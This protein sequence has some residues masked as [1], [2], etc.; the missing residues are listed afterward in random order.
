MKR[1]LKRLLIALG[2]VIAFIAFVGAC[3]YLFLWK[4]S[5]QGECNTDDSARLRVARLRGEVVGKNLWLIQYRWLRRRFTAVGTTLSLRR[6]MPATEYKGNV[7]FPSEPAGDITIDRSGTFDFGALSPGEYGLTVKMPG[8]D[9][10]DFGLQI[11][12]TTRITEV[13]I[14]ASPALLQVL[15]LELR[16]AVETHQAVA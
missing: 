16:A 13:L 15:W 10:V 14:D 9:A 12:P 6:S 1:A 2:G 4:P 5:L 8:E 3:N 11:D 7:F